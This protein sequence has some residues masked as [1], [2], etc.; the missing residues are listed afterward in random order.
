[1]LLADLSLRTGQ[2]KLSKHKENSNRRLGPSERKEKQQ[3]EQKWK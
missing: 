2:G 1:M 3:S